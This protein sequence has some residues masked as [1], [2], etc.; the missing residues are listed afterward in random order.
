MVNFAGWEMPVWYTTTRDE[1]QAIRTTAG[2]FDLS[3]MGVLDFEGPDAGRVLDMLCTNYVVWLQEGQSHYS[4]LLDPDG[5]VIDDIFI[6]RVGRERYLVVVNAANAQKAE[7]WFKAANEGEVLIDNRY[8]FKAL[9]GKCVIRNLKEPS[10]GSRQLVDLAL[11]GPSSGL[12][13]Q[14]VLDSIKDTRKLARL[15][16]FGVMEASIGGS[17]TY[18]ARTGYTGEAVGFEVFIHPDRA[19]AFWQLVLEKGKSYGM[20]PCGLGARDSARTEAG[21]PLYGHELAGP[22]SIGPGG[23]GYASFVRLNKPFFVGRAEY[24][25][26]EQTRQSAV[27]RFR[28]EAPGVRMARLGDPVV[29]NRG[30]YVGAVTSSVMAGG[31]QVGM[32]YIDRRY[33][34]PGTKLAM[35]PGASQSESI[36]SKPPAHLVSGDRVALP[37]E[38]TVIERFMTPKTPEVLQTQERAGS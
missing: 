29:N 25:A 2:L 33:V 32:A 19:P 21:L 17:Q 34:A 8:P 3:H 4:Y 36:P 24:I 18:I 26:A 15:P 12:V 22:Y 1:H 6:Y 13:L 31:S 37:V 27:V 9:D 28:I 35:F 10:A 20:L 7:D 23:A 5:Q 11:Q 14:S 16:K 30:A 38:A